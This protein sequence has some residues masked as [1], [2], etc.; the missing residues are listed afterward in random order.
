MRKQQKFSATWHEV[1][2]EGVGQLDATSVT[3]ELANSYCS[4]AAAVNIGRAIPLVTDGLKP[5]QRRV[6][7]AMHELNLRPDAPFKKVA[8][9]DGDVTG[10]LHPHGCLSYDTKIMTM[11]GKFQTIGDL[12]SVGGEHWVLSWDI[13]EQR[14]VAKIARAFRVGKTASISY[15]IKLKGYSEPITCTGNHEFLADGVWTRA[16]KLAPG[17]NLHSAAFGSHRGYPCVA[18]GG[19]ISHLHKTYFDSKGLEILEPGLKY[20]SYA[21]T[22]EA[23]F[24]YAG[25]WFAEIESVTM[26]RH[27]A[28]D[29]FDCTVDGTECFF[30][31]VGDKLVLTHNSGVGALVGMAQDHGSRY[32]YIDGQGNFGTTSDP[33]AA[34]RYIEAR[35]HV[36][37]QALLLTGLDEHTVQWKDNYDGSLQEP[38]SLP[39]RLPTL[40]LRDTAGIGVAAACSHVSY[41]LHEVAQLAAAAVQGKLTTQE[42]AL[43][44]I[45]AP[46]FAMGGLIEPSFGLTSAMITGQGSFHLLAKLHI[47]SDLRQIVAT[48]LPQDVSPERVLEQTRSAI[49]DGKLDTKWL[50]DVRDESDRFGTR[51]VWEYTQRA[52]PEALVLLLHRYTDCRV[53]VSVSAYA[54]KPDLSGLQLYGLSDVANEWAAYRREC[55]TSRQQHL[56]AAAS[57]KL[58][59]VQGQLIA[60]SHIQTVAKALIEGTELVAIAKLGLSAEQA[61][62]IEAMPL[63]SLKAAS[64][65][66]LEA[67]ERE[68]QIQI[69]TSTELLSSSGAMT[70]YLLAD[71]KSVARQL[72]DAR[73]TQF[74]GSDYDN[75]IS[76]AGSKYFAEQASA[77]KAPEHHG[78]LI[79][80]ED[81]DSYYRQPGQK[82]K[83][84]VTV[85]SAEVLIVAIGSNGMLWAI[86]PQAVPMGGK[87]TTSI[88]RLV[89]DWTRQP[90][91]PQVQILWHSLVA[92]SDLAETKLWLAGNHWAKETAL[93]KLISLEGADSLKRK[94]K[95]LGLLPL[96]VYGEPW[97]VTVEYEDG[98]KS[99]FSTSVTSLLPWHKLGTIMRHSRLK[100]V[101]L[102]NNTGKARLSK[103]VRS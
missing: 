100:Q 80:L 5:S 101:E 90:L 16:D 53:S 50:V 69:D 32:K 45:V 19:V 7:Y 36:N 64:R 82:H 84:Y 78:W 67:Q 6:L 79:A 49:A 55:E 28:I 72:G 4:Y 40:L 42:S 21:S 91:D 87:E 37:G 57:S 75:A 38:V 35:V 60:L 99:A 29:F 81:S 27:E 103:S 8:R 41:N 25:R 73:R 96:I 10:K 83:E 52:H 46:D 54:V 43:K 71:I 94:P 88:R 13:A 17:Q 23:K 33:A 74:Y 12:A 14:H 2:P 58:H 93:C 11:D 22:E 30:I 24:K 3:T 48:E 18:S 34:A 97:I 26:L 86:P 98:H 95:W 39:S 44:Y 15:E 31:A 92:K 59:L 62:A 77:P 85:D 61:A 56:L 89:A 1:Y 9:I 102:G 70:K 63:R 76:E 65:E 20:T 47:D 51:V 68:L 66:R